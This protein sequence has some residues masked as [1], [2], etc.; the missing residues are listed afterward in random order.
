[1]QQDAVTKIDA[2]EWLKHNTLT[3]EQVTIGCRYLTL[4]NLGQSTKTTGRSM[5]DLNRAW[6]YLQECTD[7]E[8]SGVMEE[9]KSWRQ[10]LLKKKP[11]TLT[12]TAVQSLL[13]NCKFLFEKKDG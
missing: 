1:M 10:T 6:Q 3:H 12:Y 13:D 5:E 11:T 7:E 9:Y 4:S 8:W 2:K